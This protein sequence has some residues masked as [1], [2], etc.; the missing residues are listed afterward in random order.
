MKLFG[1]RSLAVGSSG[2]MPVERSGA[3]IGGMPLTSVLGTN[4][5]AFPRFATEKPFGAV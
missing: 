2:T 5:F 3:T 4:E 1:L